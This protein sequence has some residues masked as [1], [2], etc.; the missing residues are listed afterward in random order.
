[1]INDFMTAIGYLKFHDIF[2]VDVDGAVGPLFFEI[3]DISFLKISSTTSTHPML[4]V[5][6]NRVLVLVLVVSVR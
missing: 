1:M 6:V 2:S 3:V 5:L 4:S